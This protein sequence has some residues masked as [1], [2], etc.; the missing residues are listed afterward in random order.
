MLLEKSLGQIRKSVEMKFMILHKWFH[1]NRMTLNREKCH[2]M[3]TII[4]IITLISSKMKRGLL[5]VIDN[6]W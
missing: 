2:Y 4:V 3:V 6:R 1:E 5:Y